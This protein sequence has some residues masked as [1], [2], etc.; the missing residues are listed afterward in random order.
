VAPLR[1]AGGD[2]DAALG[3][4]QGHIAADRPTEAQIRVLDFARFIQMIVSDGPG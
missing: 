2:Q 1:Q 4:Q 3:A